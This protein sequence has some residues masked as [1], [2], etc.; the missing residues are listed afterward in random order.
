MHH[1]RVHACMCA[2]MCVATFDAC[3][4]ATEPRSDSRQPPTAFPI[5]LHL[6]DRGMREG[7]PGQRRPRPGCRRQQLM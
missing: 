1:P 5:R 6:S 3:L 7:A 2:G 4:S